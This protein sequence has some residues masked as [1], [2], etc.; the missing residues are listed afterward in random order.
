MVAQGVV[1]LGLHACILFTVA[2]CLAC[3]HRS[4]SLR[5]CAS[6]IAYSRRRQG[7]AC[8]QIASRCACPWPPIAGSWFAACGVWA[9]RR[10]LDPAKHSDKVSSWR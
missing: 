10:Q 6:R 8:C 5:S 4:S 2:C 9:P 3:C 1:S 7:V